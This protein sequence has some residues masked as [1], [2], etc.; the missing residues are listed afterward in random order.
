M[1]AQRVTDTGRAARR[2]AAR[3]KGRSLQAGLGGAVVAGVALFALGLQDATPAPLAELFDTSRT[4]AVAD[5]QEA[6]Q[7]AAEP[8]GQLA[9]A[10]AAPAP[11]AAPQVVEQEKPVGPV[12]PPLPSMPTGP[13]INVAKGG[14]ISAALAK[15]KPGD[16]VLVPGGTYS[17][18]LDVGVNGAP[19]KPI[20]IQAVPGQKVTITGGGG[21]NGLIDLGGRSN[22]TMIGIGVKGSDSHGIFA[23]G[24]KN[25][26][27]RDC[28][29]ADSQDGGI[30]FLESS[31]I[32]VQR[33]DIH[34]NN[35]RGTSASNEAMSF[36]HT[37]NFEISFSKV[38]GNGEEGIDAKYESSAGKI[39]SNTVDG[40]RGPNIYV[41]SAKDV[42]V[43]NNT[44]TGTTEESKA[45]ISIAVENLSDTKR[46]ANIKVY[47]N[48]VRGNAGGGIGFWTESSGTFSGI[49]ILNN[50]VVNNSGSDL[51]IDGGNFSGLN[52]LRNNILGSA[53]GTGSFTAD[54]NIIGSIGGLLDNALK[55]VAGSKA[56]GAGSPDGAPIFDITGAKRTGGIDIGAFEH[57]TENP[58]VALTGLV[59]E[60]QAATGQLT[61][62]LATAV[63]GSATRA[64]TDA[65]D[66]SAA[67]PA[68]PQ[69][70]AQQDPAPPADAASSGY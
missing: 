19:G 47:N 21:G 46:A 54:H 10:L 2:R 27:L 26:V 33:C 41:D 37:D 4:R 69:P 63:L 64:P 22:I 36:D 50:T 9:P 55:V 49:Q 45:G 14:S 29:V 32:K 11:A 34:G 30:V 20:T 5:Q 24:A 66:A 60:I 17:G 58:A 48:V 23:Q 31:N 15:A 25:I 18:G 6:E 51:K 38:H 56:I 67:Q 52:I 70:P 12:P 42:E 61:S 35:A 39:F 62:G 68:Q 43:F 16:T 7:P 40:N 3:R 13:V 57:V 59:N 28:E 8:A 1:R 53:G 44:V 65:S